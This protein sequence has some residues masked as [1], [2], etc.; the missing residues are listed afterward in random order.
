MTDVFIRSVMVQDLPAIEA[1]LRFAYHEAYDATYGH[2]IIEKVSRERHSKSA[3]K[4]ML[5]RAW[6]EFTLADTGSAIAGVAYAFQKSDEIV[7][8][9]HLYVNPQLTGQGIGAQLLTESFEAFPDAKAFRLEVD[10]NNMRAIRFY[11]SFG[12]R[13]ITRLFTH[14]Q[15]A[16][17]PAIIM[18]RRM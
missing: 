13:E 9:Q 6:S 10:E 2:E 14:V 4:A 15:G 18:E 7:E 5:D 11:E 1:F 3:L 16:D 8:L 12:F 17:L